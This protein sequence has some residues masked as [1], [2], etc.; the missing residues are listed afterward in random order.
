MLS[1]QIL[2]P[3]MAEKPN[4]QHYTS[5]FVIQNSSGKVSFGLFQSQVFVQIFRFLRTEVVNNKCQLTTHKEAI[6]VLHNAVG[7]WVS[8]F[9]GKKVLEGVRFDVISIMR[10]NFQGKS[11]T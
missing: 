11:V 1:N 5:M 9:P 8:A 2:P 7:V 10:G 4:T 6:R 3:V